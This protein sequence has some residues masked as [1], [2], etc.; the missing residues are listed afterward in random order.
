MRSGADISGLIQ[1]SP[2]F[3]LIRVS[4]SAIPFVPTAIASTKIADVLAGKGA[5][6]GCA[7]ALRIES[8]RESSHN[9]T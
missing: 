4:K 9:L 7:Q 8:F 6:K 3:D 2:L 1:L 5:P